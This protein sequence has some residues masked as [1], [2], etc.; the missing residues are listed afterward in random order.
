MTNT[1]GDVKGTTATSVGLN[2]QAG[3]GTQ[4]PIFGGGNANPGGTKPDK[5]ADGPVP[6]PK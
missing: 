6:M 5:P 4:K 1:I 3:Q 2:N